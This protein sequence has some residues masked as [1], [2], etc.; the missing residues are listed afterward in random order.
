MVRAGRLAP[1]RAVDLGC[2]TG[3]NAVFLA[4]H[5]FDVT[6]IDFALAALAKATAKATAAGVCIRFIKDGLTA[7]HHCLGT[8]D[9]LVDCGTLDDFSPGKRTRYVANVIPLAGPD[10]QF[11][12]WCFQ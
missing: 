4:Q 8:F 12:L 6:G 5:G 7:L 3:A 11:L 1:G 2:G 9:L 10:A